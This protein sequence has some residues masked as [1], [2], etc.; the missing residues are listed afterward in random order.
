[1]DLLHLEQLLE[2]AATQKVAVL[3]DLML[4]RFVWG[5][6]TRISP[7]APVP[8]VAVNRESSYPGGAANVARNLKQFC[9]EVFIIGSLGEDSE[10]E[11]LQG[12]MRAEGLNTQYLVTT[13]DR[14]TSLKM[15]II[16][17]HQ[18][19]VRV[20]REEVVTM[21]PSL[22]PQLAVQLEEVA[23]QVDAFLLEDYGKGF[24]YQ[25]LVDHV[26]KVAGGKL[27][28]CDPHPKNFLEM[29]GFA[30]V[31]PNRQ[32][33]FAAAGVPL[34]APVF[35]VLEDQPLLQVG[36][37]LLERWCV[38][39]LLITLGE[40]GMILFERGLA[41]YHTPTRAQE[42]FDVS[43]AGDTVIA[44]YTLA[45]AGGATA[46]EAAEIANHAAGIVVGKLGTAICTREEL[47]RS[48]R[49]S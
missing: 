17:Q 8:V 30:V 21:P 11:E 6:V 41:P 40:Q 4:D 38:Q 25:E 12:L 14:P 49:H 15:R 36:E 44:L 33:A 42:V 32:E 3:G 10:G 39:A 13:R 5:S 27:I 18:Q 31:K 47:L 35:P 37:H 29:P 20:D 43:G 34:S 22:S 7:E 2:Q 28:T 19:V 23:D 26:R 24:L 16:A 48:F 9:D 46:Q 45:L 1:M